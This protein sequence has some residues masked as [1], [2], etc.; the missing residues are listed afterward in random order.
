[1]M[2][3]SKLRKCLNCDHP[4]ELTRQQKQARFEEI[5]EAERDSWKDVGRHRIVAGVAL[6]AFGVFVAAV[7]FVAT[8]GAIVAGLILPA[9]GLAL[10]VAGMIKALTG[11]D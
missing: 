5:R 2:I 8:G 3:D 6:I 11:K 1:M 7:S 9:V 4:V 10:I